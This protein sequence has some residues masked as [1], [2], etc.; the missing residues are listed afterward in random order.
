MAYTLYLLGEVAVCPLCSGAVKRYE[1]SLGIRFACNDCGGI[2]RPKDLGMAEKE[3][4]CDLIEI[5]SQKK[6]PL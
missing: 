1:T 4:V 6:L 3:I 2:F 5:R